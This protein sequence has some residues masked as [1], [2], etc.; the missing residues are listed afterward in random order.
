MRGHA[1]N[2]PT[3]GGEKAEGIWC[4]NE[5]LRGA[6]PGCVWKRGR[7]RGAVGS[8]GRNQDADLGARQ[9]LGQEAVDA[10]GLLNSAG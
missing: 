3:R 4:V 2:V 10:A 1:L 5:G 9:V 6:D 8:E 7:G